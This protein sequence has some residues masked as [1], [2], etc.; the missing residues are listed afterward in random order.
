MSL[1]LLL[2][3]GALCLLLRVWV[4]G[5]LTCVCCTFVDYYRLRFVLGGVSC[6]TIW[7]VNSVVVFVSYFVGG[8]LGTYVCCC[9][10]ACCW[11]ELVCVVVILVVLWVCG[12]LV[13]RGFCVVGVLF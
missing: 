4:G 13:L 1:L 5:L 12:I 11:F 8:L 9:G 10:F 7:L 3:L 2:F 6:M